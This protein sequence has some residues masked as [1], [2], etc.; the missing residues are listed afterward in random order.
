MSGVSELQQKRSAV[1]QL[2]LNGKKQ[3]QILRTLGSPKYSRSFISRTIK[4]YIE[5]GKITDIQRSGRPRT[6]RT[7]ANKKKIRQILIR[8]PTT[9]TRKV[10]AKVGI[11]RESARRIIKK[12]LGIKCFKR[13]R[14][15][16]LNAKT[17]S[18]RIE[19]CRKL[20]AWLKNVNSD[21]IVFS[22]EKKFCIEDKYNS[23][24]S[25]VY[26]LTR[27]DIPEKFRTV[28]KTQHPKSIMVWAGIS[29]F[30]KNPLVFI[31]DGMKINAD[32]YMN[33]ILKKYVLPISSTFMKNTQWVFQQDGAPAHT[34]KITQDWLSINL[35]GFLSRED[36]PPASPD[37]NPCDYYLWGRLE[38]LVNNRAYD[39]I[40]ALK[41]TLSK[42]WSELDQDEVARACSLF[43][44]RVRSCLKARGNRFEMN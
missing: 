7:P 17:I 32:L 23:K 3:N 44:D 6:V 41:R 28:Q 37:L 39:N 36:W 12:D 8:R 33:H 19:R 20:L 10:A 21:S 1:I 34:A 2:F 24:N 29:A 22:D 27:E 43:P 35:P 42:V 5:T 26:S 15:E 4:R 14:V 31:P 25:C 13:T 40:P 16:S 11:D 9:S 38:E 30:G 18:K